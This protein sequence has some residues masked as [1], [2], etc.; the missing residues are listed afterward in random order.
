MARTLR[1]LAEFVGGEVVGDGNIEIRRV[2][3]I[4]KAEEGDITFLANPKYEKAAAETR[5]SAII[6]SP[7]HK[8][9]S[10]NLLVSDNPYLA[11]AKIL[12][13]MYGDRPRPAAGIHELAVVSETAKI[14]KDVHIGPN[15]FIGEEVEIGDRVVIYPCVYIGDKCKVGADT[16]IYPNAVIYPDS[17]IGKRVVLHANVTIGSD[18]FGFAPNGEKYYPIPQVGIAVI[19][20][21]V[22]I[23][24]NS[25]I[26]RGALDKTIIR[27][28]T[29]IDSNCVISHNVDVGENTLMISLVGVSGSTKIGKHVTLAGQVG[30][31]GHL[32][33]GDNVTVG[34][35]AGVTHDLTAN[36][37]YLG[38]PAAPIEETRQ[39]IAALTKLPKLRKQIR[40][41]EKKVE[42]LE[43]ELRSIKDESNRSHS[44]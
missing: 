35:Q 6:V 36:K 7:E 16:I 4:D 20:D 12:R 8:G 29:K 18:G 39:R 17:I 38:S 27:R 37:T 40:E 44:G 30:V 31:A 2:M 11:F 13:Y 24:A 28:G 9:I 32:E 33:I 26:N 22:S 15:A 34:A 1:E 3:P 43:E 41:L 10:K 25:V 42:A 21:D 14:G 19:E 5:A 23:G